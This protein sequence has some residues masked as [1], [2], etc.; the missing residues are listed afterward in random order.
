MFLSKPDPK[1]KCVA[2]ELVMP[3]ESV[4]RYIDEKK[5][6]DMLKDAKV[7]PKGMLMKD[8]NTKKIEEVLRSDQFISMV[9]CYKAGKG[10]VCIKIEQREPI[11]YILPD[12]KDGYFIDADGVKI[13]NT[14]Y[15]MNMVTASGAIDDEF[16][17]T[18]LAQ[19]GR[20]I[21]SNQFW[22]N[23]IEQIYVSKKNKKP[24]IE[25]IPRVG[26]HII[27]LGSIDDFEK[28]LDHLKAFYDKAIKQVGWD[29]YEKIDLQYGNQVICT[30]RN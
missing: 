30:K 9:E 5:V 24:V 7:Y 16:A 22:N 25:L 15:V 21:N 29:K 28:K 27:Y 2:V 23:Q 14:S 8:V 12:G 17:K 26:D 1:E 6:E 13:S 18:E 20:Y 3:Q 19:L 10:K 11:I 4:V